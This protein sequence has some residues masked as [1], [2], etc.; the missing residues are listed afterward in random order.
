KIDRY[1]RDLFGHFRTSKFAF[2]AQQRGELIDHVGKD[3]WNGAH[4]L[5]SSTCG[6]F[7][8]AGK[9]EP[10]RNGPLEEHRRPFARKICNDAEHVIDAALSE[11]GRDRPELLRY[12]VGG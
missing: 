1:L 3:F 6:T 12:I 11:R 2:L 9:R 8:E 7:C 5:V 10:A 4:E